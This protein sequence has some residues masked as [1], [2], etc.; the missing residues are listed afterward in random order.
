MFE[1]SIQTSDGSVLKRLELSGSRPV[2]IGR[3]KECDI[4]IP[5][6]SISRHHAELVP[7]DEAREWIIR[8]LGSTHGVKIKGS[9]INEAT[10]TPGMEVHLGPI[11]LKF[12]SLTKRIGAELDALLTE[13]EDDGPTDI[14]VLG[15]FTRGDA[16]DATVDGT[17]KRKG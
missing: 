16:L 4:R 3:S 5:V 17:N 6:P 7:L 10:I 8:D 2:R 11:V 13:D 9:P 1:V 14:T 12:D 15:N